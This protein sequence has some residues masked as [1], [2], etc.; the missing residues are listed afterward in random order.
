MLAGVGAKVNR[1]D[2][3]REERHQCRPQRRWRTDHRQ[4]RAVVG[5]IGRD[6]PHVS[7][8]LDRGRERLNHCRATP[9]ADVRHGF[10]QRHAGHLYHTQAD[11]VHDP[12]GES[13]GS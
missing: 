13:R 9:L 7:V 6:K 2:R 5:R 10:D 1:V 12:G 4:H 8:A 11:R 3:D